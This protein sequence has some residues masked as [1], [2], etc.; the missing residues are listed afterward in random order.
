MGRAGLGICTIT[1]FRAKLFFGMTSGGNEAGLMP[2]IGLLGL[3]GYR[4]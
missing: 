3:S 2:S 4:S 1:G